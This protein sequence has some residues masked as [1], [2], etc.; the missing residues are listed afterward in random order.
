M[1][2]KEIQLFTQALQLAKDEFYIDSLNAFHFLI[3]D[4]PDSELVDDSLFNI[5]L[6]YFNMNQFNKA[7]ESFNIVIESHPNATISILDGGNEYGLTSAKCYLGIIN[8]H[9][10]MGNTDAAQ[11]NF[12]LLENYSDS[13]IVRSNGEKESFYSIAKKAINIYTGINP[14]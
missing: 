4:F 12:K 7:I 8:C 6:C 11:S 13:Y 5:G 14:L 3:K 2:S 10:G 9:L 1:H